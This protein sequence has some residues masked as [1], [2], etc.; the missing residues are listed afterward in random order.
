MP[1]LTRIAIFTLLTAAVVQKGIAQNFFGYKSF[2]LTEDN[3]PFKIN[4][5]Y[6]TEEGFIYAGTTNGLYTFDG[7]YFSKINFLN[8]AVKDTVTAIF[9]DNKKQLWAGFKNGKIAKKINDR[10]QYFEPE[11]GTPKVAITAF[12]QDKQNNIWFATNGEGIY[13]FSNNHLYLI[14]EEEGL[15]DKYVHALTLADNGDVL[16]ATD[17]GI[18]ICSISGAKKTVTVI[19][20][21]NGLPDYYITSIV[22]AGNNTFWVGMQ[23]KGFCLYNHTTKQIAIPPAANNW[24]FGQINTLLAS[25]NSLWIATQENGLFKLSEARQL[26]LPVFSGSTDKNNISNL[27]LDDEANIWMTTADELISNSGDKL[28]LLPLY[29]KATYETIHTILSDYQ[30]NIWAGTDG[31]LI[32]YSFADNKTERKNFPIKGLTSKTDI[33]GLYQDKY[34]NIWISTM[35]EGVFVLDPATGK[36]R[37]ISENPLLK[38]AS[39]LS[40]TGSG[41][42]VCAGGL[43]GVATIFELSDLNKTIA[44]NYQFTNYNNIP[45]IGN[46]YIHTV[47]KDKAGGLWFGTD[48]KGITV[49]QNGQFVHYNKKNGLKDEHVYSFTED[50][51]GRIWFN[52]KDAGIYSFDGVKFKNY[53]AA[54]GISDL[55]ITTL[56]TDRLGNIIIVNEKGIDILNPETGTVSYLNNVQGIAAI[57]TAI[58]SITTD[59]YDNILL[60]TVNGIVK[61]CPIAKTNQQPKTIINSVQLFLQVINKEEQHKFK[62]DE[63]GFT[64][65]FTG[66]Y[67]T[68]PA[69]VHYQYKL[70]GWDSS[71]IA[72]KDQ[73][74]PFPNLRPGKYTFHVRSSL[75][76]NFNNASEATYSF[77]IYSPFWKRWWF[78]ILSV[79]AGAGILIGYMKW[80]EKSIT[81]MQQLQQ[82]KI[83]FQFEVLRNQVNPHFLFNSF[84]TLISAIEEN[85][86]AAVDYV[87]QLSE[88]FRNIVNYRDKDVITLG[89][90]INLLKTYFYLQQK[91]YG[92]NLKLNINISEEEKKQLLIPPLTLQLLIEN[93]IKHNAVSKE[94][95]LTID[96]LMQNSNRLIIR[97]NINPKFSPQSG[98]GMGLQNIINRYHILSAEAV[99]VNNDNN[100][101]TVSLPALK[102]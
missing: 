51:K 45:N 96:L 84:N 58:E 31:G 18:N 5:L 55:K 35:G 78:I 53:G 65:I 59:T 17:Q 1:L 43:E 41:N 72:T 24:S 70:D 47:Y 99:L 94:T 29:D 37:N 14:N 101:F 66:L 81:K 9:Q 79:I 26:L 46:N 69:E 75:N 22:P 15:S 4:T 90:E 95:I 100:F 21:K 28:T 6:K 97:N 74:I 20:P 91:R 36:Y 77:T 73:S 62:Y 16:A 52:T 88:F 25:A 85:P 64:F 32:K 54:Q 3:K 19:G 63:N 93:A 80:R 71:W 30:N 23:E 49:L 87:E 2:A 12:V 38:K 61:Y 27:L 40:I 10:L 42:T 67:Y 92:D 83:Q 33:T 11:E 102:Q 39:L 98:T 50:Q 76:E 57:N 44:E 8:P 13:Y 56:K 82:E 34:H 48:G 68:N 7:K 86:K 60:S 89:E